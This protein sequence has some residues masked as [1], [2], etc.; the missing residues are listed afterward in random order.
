[1]SVW[2][3]F[4]HETIKMTPKTMHQETLIDIQ[5]ESAFF[6]CINPKLL[7]AAFTLSQEFAEN[8]CAFC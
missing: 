4:K 1:M 8:L 7:T 3:H 5:L 6:R 2:A